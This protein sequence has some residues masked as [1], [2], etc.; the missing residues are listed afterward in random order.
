MFKKRLGQKFFDSAENIILW[1]TWKNLF[2]LLRDRI[3]QHQAKQKFFF[4]NVLDNFSFKLFI[5]LYNDI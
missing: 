4:C 5:V 3:K 1:L 2:G